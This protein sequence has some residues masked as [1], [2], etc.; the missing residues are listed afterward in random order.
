V[1]GHEGKNKGDCRRKYEEK[2]KKNVYYFNILQEM[3]VITFTQALSE[4]IAMV[5]ICT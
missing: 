2:G 3:K 1:K 5:T 4:G